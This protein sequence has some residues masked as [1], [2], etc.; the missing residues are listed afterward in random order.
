MSAETQQQFDMRFLTPFE[1]YIIGRLDYIDAQLATINT[2]VTD[3]FHVTVNVKCD[4]PQPPVP[5]VPPPAPAAPKVS[6]GDSKNMIQYPYTMPAFTGGATGN[7]FSYIET[8]ADGTV[9]P[10]V[11]QN[12]STSNDTGT[13]NV[14]EKSKVEYWATQSDAAGNKSADSVHGIID[15]AA[16]TVP[17]PAPDAPTTGPGDTAP[18][19]PSIGRG[20][21]KK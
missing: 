21:Q 12:H 3:G 7:T 8:L 2:R 6:R 10:Q 20:V 14:A 18:M 1:R 15:S 17:P 5:P 9:N 16:D 4:C 11:D 13:F 19:A